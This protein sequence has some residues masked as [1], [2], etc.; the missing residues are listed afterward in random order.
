MHVVLSLLCVL[1]FPQQTE[2]YTIYEDG[3]TAETGWVEKGK[4]SN[5]EEDYGA[6]PLLF[7]HY[8]SSQKRKST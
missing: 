2:D 6:I 3:E 5:D 4:Q 8:Y 7:H 1:L